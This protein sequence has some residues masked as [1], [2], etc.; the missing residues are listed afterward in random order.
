MTCVRT[1]NNVQSHIMDVQSR[2]E[3]VLELLEEHGEVTVSELSERT[4]V[5][6]MTIRRDLELLEQEGVL[7][8]V[9]G[10][11]ISAASRGYAAPFSVRSDRRAD[12]KARIGEA[13]AAMLSERETVILDVGTTTLAVARA[14]HGRRNLTVLTPSLQIANL[15]SKDRGIRLMVTGGTVTVGEM[16]LIG[17]LAEEAFSRLRFDTLVMGVGGVEVGAGCTEFNQDDARVKRAALAS[18]RR[19]IVVAD[20]SKLGKITFA[21][22]CTID[23][24]DVLVTDSDAAQEDLALF[25]SENVEVVVV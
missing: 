10:G 20:S 18:V 25:E 11:A 6:P 24:V 19:C 2:R 9:H 8:R 13:V 15:L 4:G 21:Q 12:A 3:L 22:I 16:S 1:T 5:S 14:L 17:D 7:K 23:L